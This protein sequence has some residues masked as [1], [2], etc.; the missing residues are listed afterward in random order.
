M[1]PTEVLEIVALGEDSHHQFKENVNNQNSLAAEIVAFSNSGGGKILIGVSDDSDITGLTR[2]D[3]KR[4][5]NLISNAASQSVRPPVN[6]H[7]ENI[8]VGEKNIIVLCI[9]SGISKPYMDNSGVI[10]VKSGADK[11][12]VTSRDEMQRMF[13]SAGLVHADEIPTENCTITELDMDYFKQFYKKQY[14]ES[15]EEQ[16]ISLPVIL[17]NMNLMRQGTFNLAGTLLFTTKPQIRLPITTIK[18]V[19][20]PG[21]DIH[22]SEFRDSEDLSGKLE[23]VYKASLSFVTRNISHIQDSKD[24]NALGELEIPRIVFEELLTNALIHRDYFVSSNIRIFIFDNRV[25]LISPGHLP[26]NLTLENIKSG[27]SN[28]RNPIL[29]S[30]GTKMLPYRGLGSGIRRALAA[31][32]DIEFLDDQDG[33]QFI[34]TIKR[35]IEL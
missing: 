2:E 11:R 15:V 20:Y 19:C 25:E 27:V 13:Q 28:I 14:L 35:Q 5:N 26:N 9:P 22:V 7:S 8:Q 23:E 12:R 18:C 10:W 24:V 30:Y 16:E 1:E 3:I 6:P 4:L 33:N 31:Y 17:E 21:N 34:V 29:A 32:R